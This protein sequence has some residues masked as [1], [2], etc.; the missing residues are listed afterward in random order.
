[1]PERATDALRDALHRVS[2]RESLLLQGNFASQLR[3]PT[4][5]AV[6]ELKRDGLSAMNIQFELYALA[7]EAGIG[8]ATE[9]LDALTAWCVQRYYAE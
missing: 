7:A 4:F 1:M 2:M 5:A 8:T 6:D 3:E 9:V